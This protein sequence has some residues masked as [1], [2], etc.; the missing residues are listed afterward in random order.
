MLPTPTVNMYYWCC[1]TVEI[2]RVSHLAIWFIKN[3][4]IIALITILVSN[5]ISN[6]TLFATNNTDTTYIQVPEVIRWQ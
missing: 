1:G 6:F 3:S 2:F 4:L 5:L